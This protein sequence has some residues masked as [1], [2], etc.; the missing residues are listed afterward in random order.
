MEDLRASFKNQRNDAKLDIV[1]QLTQNIKDNYD[2]DNLFAVLDYYIQKENV[3][4]HKLLRIFSMFLGDKEK[5]DSLIDDI[6]A[7]KEYLDEQLDAKIETK[8]ESYHNS[9]QLESVVKE[10]QQIDSQSDASRGSNVQ[11]MYDISI[12]SGSNDNYEETTI[13]LVE[14]IDLGEDMD[15]EGILTIDGDL[16]SEN[17]VISCPKCHNNDI[18]VISSTEIYCI[19]CQ[20]DFM[21]EKRGNERDSVLIED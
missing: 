8:H 2:N 21:I 20:K 11:D 13:D 6:D 5:V 1:C 9:Q 18:V 19:D 15:N 3:N 17:T 12:V 4:Y 7:M 16:K 14:S 10:F